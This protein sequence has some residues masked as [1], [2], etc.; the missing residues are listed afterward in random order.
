[1]QD[2]FSKQA[3]QISFNHPALRTVFFFFFFN[4]KRAVREELQND[5]TLQG[6]VLPNTS[7][8][9]TAQPRPQV[10]G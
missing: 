7:N 6:S 9:P 1:M 4:A 2:V 3:C 8:R 10:P 5:S